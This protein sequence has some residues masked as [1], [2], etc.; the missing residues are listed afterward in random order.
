MGLDG[1]GVVGDERGEKLGGIGDVKLLTTLAD[2]RPAVQVADLDLLATGERQPADVAIG[3][4]RAGH[5]LERGEKLPEI[6]DRHRGMD[7]DV[8]VGRGDNHAEGALD[9]EAV[10][11]LPLRREEEDRFEHPGQARVVD[12]GADPQQLLLEVAVA[13]DGDDGEHLPA[14]AGLGRGDRRLEKYEESN[15]GGDRAGQSTDSCTDHD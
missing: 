4:H 11:P 2:H 1:K 7:A 15:D 6:L 13:V 10:E 5:S 14:G 9:I 12:M 3:L 8:V